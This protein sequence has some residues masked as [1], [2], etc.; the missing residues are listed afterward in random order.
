MREFAPIPAEAERLGKVVV[1][2]AM[3]VHRHLG[4]GFLERVYEDAFATNWNCARFLSRDRKRS[5]SP[6]KTFS[7]QAKGWTSSS[8]A[9]SSLN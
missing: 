6:T 3:E 9:R 4:A 5:Q 7:Y 1:D 2:A 8:V